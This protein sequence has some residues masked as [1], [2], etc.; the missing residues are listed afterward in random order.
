MFQILNEIIQNWFDKK[1]VLQWFKYSA[2]IL[3]LSLSACDDDETTYVIQDDEPRPTESP[4]SDVDNDNGDDD[5][6]NPTPTFSPTPTPTPVEP[7]NE[8]V[9]AQA[10][11]NEIGDYLIAGEGS[12]QWEGYTLYTFNQDDEGVSECYDT[13]EETWPPFVVEEDAELILEDGIAGTLSVVERTDG[14][15]QVTFNG[16]PLYFY[17]G[18][19]AVGDYNGNGNNEA[20]W[21]V[22]LN[23]SAVQVFESQDLGNYLVAGIG[24]YEGHALYTFA[25]DDQGQS[26]CDEVCAETWPPF[27]VNA[28]NQ[29]ILDEDIVGEL[30]YTRREDGDMQVTYNN[31][32]L[33]FY[34]PDTSAGD[35]GG[36]GIN[37]VWYVVYPAETTV[38]ALEVDRY[39]QILVS[40]FGDKKGYSLYTFDNDEP[41]VSNCDE[42]CISAWPP[43]LVDSLESDLYLGAGLTGELGVMS[44]EDETYQVT[45]NGQPLYYFSGDEEVGDTNGHGN[46]DVW[47]L[48]LLDETTIDLA[49]VDELGAVIVAGTGEYKGRTLYQFDTDENGQSSCYE[50]CEDIWLPYVVESEEELQLSLNIPG[51]LGVTER[52]NGDWQVTYNEQPLYFYRNDEPGEAKGQGLNDAWWVVLPAGNTVEVYDDEDLGDILVAGYG[53]YRGFTLYTFANDS[54]NESGC[55]E[56][57]ADSW[58]PFIKLEGVELALPEGV[59]GELSEVERENGDIQVTFNGSPLYFF[60]NDEEAGDTNGQ[61]VNDVWYVVEV[62]DQEPNDSEPV[63]VSVATD[64][65]LGDYLVAQVDEGESLTLYFFDYDSHGESA[66]YGSCATTW[67][68]LLVED[69][70]QLSFADDSIL[71]ELS[72]Y[73]REDDTWQVLYNGYPV[74]FYSGDD[75]AGDVNGQGVDNLWSVI[76]PEDIADD[77]NQNEE[78]PEND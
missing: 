7:V 9:L 8:V 31:Q 25:N 2:L 73:Q 62:D 12:G 71:G 58:P 40:G 63:V 51:Q 21:I 37:D 36:Q 6:L 69:E 10:Q 29:L 3:F 26:A 50:G 78:D 67:P 55:Y 46:N 18:D 72:V 66:C 60:A 13:C 42:N 53:E 22:S 15:H 5:R 64:E 19:Q 70:E 20:W 34:A 74:Y 49:N 43:L 33:Y 76:A 68:P 1:P 56:E 61:G 77:D 30:G 59:E 44:L 28:E 16:H 41:G 39:G 52:E 32:P 65:T 35:A 17:T 24:E 23:Q 14:E 48:V 4:G 57:C 47:W 54:D 11:N 38:S 27:I 75:V 45:Y